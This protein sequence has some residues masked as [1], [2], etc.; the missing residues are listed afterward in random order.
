M[1]TRSSSLMLFVTAS[2]A[3]AAACSD[4]GSPVAA[5]GA[6]AGAFPPNMVQTFTCTMDLEAES[7][8]CTDP[9][10]RTGAAAGAI[11][12]SHPNYVQFASHPNSAPA[13]EDSVTG[14]ELSM[15]VTVESR[16]IQPLG[17]LDGVT[18]HPYG[19][20]VFFNSG[21]VVTAP[22][23]PTLPA[24][25]SV[26]NADGVAFFNR[27]SKQYFQYNQ[28]LRHAEPSDAREWIFNVV[29]AKQFS[30]TL[31]VSAEVQYPHGWI[32]ITPGTLALTPGQN[33]TLIATVRAALGVPLTESVTWM[34]SNPSVATVTSLG[35]QMAQV[36][37]VANGMAWI[38]AVSTVSP[39]RRDSVMVM[40]MVWPALLPAGETRIVLTWGTSPLDLDS[41]LVGPDGSGGT[42]HVYYLNPVTTAVNL[43]GDDT[44]GFG[45]ETVTIS[46]QHAGAYCFSVHNYSGEAPLG[47]SDAQVRVFRGTQQVAIFGVP[48]TTDEVWN[49]FRMSG[50][51]LNIVNTTGSSVSGTC[52]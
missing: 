5:R 31:V 14:G 34:S 16:I 19:V 50:D 13:P 27:S 46:Q 6:E 1:S 9:S 45:L 8:V 44:Q 11:S 28:L 22:Y 24:S 18:L 32:D 10:P 38:R 41:H 51:T 37:G 36:Q 25:A 52:Q 39:F 49:V 26:A 4:S 29:N 42:F 47:T 33:D 2:L 23:D 30:F 40:V 15:F 48:D 20:R 43:D 21:P 17:T 3:A 35:S 7:L 12:I